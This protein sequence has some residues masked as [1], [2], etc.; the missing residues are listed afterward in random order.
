MINLNKVFSYE[1]MIIKLNDFL[2]N[3]DFNSFIGN[4]E[5]NSFLVL[6]SWKE[7]E[8][9]E[10]YLNR[11]IDI[12][13]FNYSIDNLFN[14]DYGFSDEYITCYGCNDI[15]SLTPSYYSE[16]T[17]YHIFECEILCHNCIDIDD[18]IE[19]VKNNTDKCIKSS[20]FSEKDIEKQGFILLNDENFQNGLHSFMNDDPKKIFDLFKDKYNEIVFYLNETSQFYIEFS[21]YGR[22]KEV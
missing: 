13:D 10:K 11:F 16:Q 6:E 12:Y 19:N 2:N 21:I 8:Q 3:N 22:N 1:N 18:L 15:I 20:L 14:S 17:K 9:I 7:V 5:N 4:Y